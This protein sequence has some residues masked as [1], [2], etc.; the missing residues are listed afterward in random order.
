MLKFHLSSFSFC[1]INIVFYNTGQLA[2][3][4]VIVSKGRPHPST[5][6]SGFI[7]ENEI[8]ERKKQRQEE[9]EKVR[10]ADQPIGSDK[11]FK[12]ELNIY[13]LKSC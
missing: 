5:M 8:A 13:N 3:L 7:S 2:L 11:I 4:P 9:W 12:I 10:T 6:S 1:F